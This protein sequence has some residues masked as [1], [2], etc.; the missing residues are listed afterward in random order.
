MAI[1]Q[2]KAFVSFVV[3]ASLLVMYRINVIDA[4]GRII[5]PPGRSSMWR[6][7]Y[8]VPTD[9]NDNGVNCGG[10]GV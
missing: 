6:F 10:F 3:L 9:Y 4:H 5:D 7:G 2:K 1:L 8:D